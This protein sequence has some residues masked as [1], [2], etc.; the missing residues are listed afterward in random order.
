MPVTR[1]TT[2]SSMRGMTAIYLNSAG[3]T[4]LYKVRRNNLRLTAGEKL[5]TPSQ[6]TAIGESLISQ[7]LG[8][9]DTLKVRLKDNT[10]NTP[11]IQP[12]HLPI[13]HAELSIT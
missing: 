9:I 1:Q 13:L 11:L 3:L 12:N 4:K 8:R 10:P 7:L 6:T 2:L 5:K